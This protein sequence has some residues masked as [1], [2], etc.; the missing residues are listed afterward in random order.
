MRHY[1][2]MNA[3]CFRSKLN[4]TSDHSDFNRAVANP[5]VPVIQIMNNQKELNIAYMVYTEFIHFRSFGQTNLF[6][7][8]LNI[9][10]F[11]EPACSEQDIAITMAPWCMCVHTCIHP[12]LSSPELRYF[13][14]VFKLILHN[15]L[16]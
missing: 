7:G 1:E 10:L 5:L 6:S 8:E 9:Y 12:D 11:V 15:C 14:M 3:T 16:F 4:F 13:W 2:V